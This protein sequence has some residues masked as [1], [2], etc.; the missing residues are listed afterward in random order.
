MH[1]MAYKIFV[2]TTIISCL[3]GIMSGV[4]QDM[5]AHSECVAA[6]LFICMVPS[7]EGRFACCAIRALRICSNATPWSTIYSTKTWRHMIWQEER[8]AGELLAGQVGR[9][10][11]DGWVNK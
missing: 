5:A 6:F 4:V 1:N 10:Q 2:I 9:F 3:S 8:G 7:K 11:A